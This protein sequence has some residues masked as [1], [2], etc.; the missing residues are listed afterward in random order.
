ML[1]PQIVLDRV[2]CKIVE[3]DWFCSTVLKVLVDDV[4][5]RV[6][7]G[8]CRRTAHGDLRKHARSGGRKMSP[9][10]RERRNH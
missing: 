2:T 7:I 9:S 4:E 5:H 10:I 8:F 6:R 1:R 3:V